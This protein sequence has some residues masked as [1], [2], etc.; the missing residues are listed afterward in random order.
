MDDPRALQ[1]S[2][3]AS[4][5]DQWDA[6]APHRKRV[7]A[8]LTKD[9]DASRTRLC[10]LGAGN[11]NDLDLPAL[12]TAHREV[13]L[14]DLDPLA[15]ADGAA[16]QGVS[17]HPGLRLIGGVDLTAMLDAMAS[18]TPQTSIGPTD[19][20]ALVEWPSTRLA[21]TL[22]GPYDVVASTCLLSQIAGNAFRAVGE[23]HPQFGALVRSIRVGHL[24][25]LSHLT[26]PGGAAILITDVVSSER[27]A[28]LKTVP[29]S[30]LEN[31]L[32]QLTREGGLI[33][34]VNPAA[35]QAEVRDDPVL[36]AR[37]ARAESSSPWRWTL[38]DRVYLVIALTLCSR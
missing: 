2:F 8:L 4:S 19:L 5:R 16:R 28:P 30:S 34:G 3:N 23:R 14:V 13:A 22:R 37:F 29:D 38:H 24:R 10:L 36:A 35:I 6:F 7:S 20:S 12:L 25:M 33:H 32:L 9:G 21:P 15:I 27:F 1:A 26:R 18:W 31:V 17:A 11:S